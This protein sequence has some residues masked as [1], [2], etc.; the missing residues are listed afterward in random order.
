MP[1]QI[2]IEI[3][4]DVSNLQLPSPELI[5]FY[6]NLSERVLWLDC[7]VDEYFLEFGRY[8]MQW[9]RE[10]IGVPVEERKPIKLLFISRGGDLDVNNAMTD[11]IAASKTP[12]YGYSMGETASAATFIFMAC[13]KRYAMP[14]SSFLLHKGSGVFQGTYDEV[15]S[16]VLDYQRKIA[17][18][19]EFIREH[20]AISDELIEERMGSEWY[21]TA[22]E[23]LELGFVDEIVTDLDVVL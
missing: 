20:S 11:I 4:Q 17:E 6:K 14:R 5:T 15:V 22:Q 18:L 7:D 10:D 2:R 12:I 21:V 9:N 23:A 13:H 8:I 16:A 19:V 1:E 3:P